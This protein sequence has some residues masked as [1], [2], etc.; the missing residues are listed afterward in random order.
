MLLGLA[1]VVSLDVQQRA[2]A[3][4]RLVLLLGPVVVVVV[5]VSVVALLSRVVVVSTASSEPPSIAETAAPAAPVVA[6][7][8]RL[9]PVA[10]LLFRPLVALVTLSGGS[11]SCRI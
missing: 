11:R 1:A 5:L 4:V 9:V 3:V 10:V 2:I 8:C 7:R 6:I